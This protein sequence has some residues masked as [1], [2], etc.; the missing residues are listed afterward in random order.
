MAKN[1]NVSDGTLLMRIGKK[2]TTVKRTGPNVF[3]RPKIIGNI[4]KPKANRVIKIPNAVKVD[5]KRKRYVNRITLNLR[6]KTNLLSCA[7]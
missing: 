1:A 2:K 4:E 7:T 5:D 6:A 3:K